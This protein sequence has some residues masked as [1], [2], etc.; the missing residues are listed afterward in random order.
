MTPRGNRLPR[1]LLP[2]GLVLAAAAHAL[3]FV[4]LG[5]HVNLPA[6]LAI[7]V[8]LV[9]LKLAVHARWRRRAMKRAPTSPGPEAPHREKARAP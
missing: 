3:M 8:V 9:V 1:E 4:Q 5:G 2:I 7:G 6:A